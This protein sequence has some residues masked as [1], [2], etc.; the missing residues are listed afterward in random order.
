M[1]FEQTETGS[2]IYDLNF[3][4]LRMKNINQTIHL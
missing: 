1:A 3:K 4:K 2:K